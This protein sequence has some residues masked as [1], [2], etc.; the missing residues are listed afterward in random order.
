MSIG[1]AHSFF[2]QSIKHRR[3]N[4]RAAIRA[5]AVVLLII[6]EDDDDIGLGTDCEGRRRNARDRHEQ[7]ES[8]DQGVS[9]HRVVLHVVNQVYAFHGTNAILWPAAERLNCA[10]RA[11]R[12]DTLQLFVLQKKSSR[13]HSVYLFCESSTAF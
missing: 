1:E 6:G 5:I 2:R 7:R 9:M 8:S 13:H 11:V 4:L 3:L 12:S 10:F